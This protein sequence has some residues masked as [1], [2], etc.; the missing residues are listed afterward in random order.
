MADATDEACVWGCCPFADDSARR[1]FGR[2]YRS[3]ADLT[4]EGVGGARFWEAVVVIM[5]E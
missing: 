1:L 5:V 4:D 3:G 2:R